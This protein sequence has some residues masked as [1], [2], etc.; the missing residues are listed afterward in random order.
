LGELNCNHTELENAHDELNHN[1]N[2]ANATIKK[3][4]MQIGSFVDANKN[5]KE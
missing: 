3:Q 1:F 2:D 5:L 4:S